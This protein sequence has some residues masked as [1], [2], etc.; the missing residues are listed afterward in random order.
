MVGPTVR[1]VS[2]R[3]ISVD[4]YHS[5]SFLCLLPSPWRDTVAYLQPSA[6][7]NSTVF[8]YSVCP[9]L[10]ACLH[11]RRQVCGSLQVNKCYSLIFTLPGDCLRA[12]I[13]NHCPE[14]TTFFCDQKR[15]M[16]FSLI[17]GRLERGRA[18]QSSACSPTL[19]PL[20]GRPGLRSRMWLS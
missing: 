16:S 4:N 15:S 5:R 11:T 14:S 18:C 7:A 17:K 9:S 3:F 6:T 20:K 2:P 19:F 13:R 1:I 10:P 12:G 8:G